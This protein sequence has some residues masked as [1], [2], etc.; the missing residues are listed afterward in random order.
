MAKLR[1]VVLAA[2]YWKALSDR[3]KTISDSISRFGKGR[4]VALA[5]ML[6]ELRS[7]SCVLVFDWHISDGGIFWGPG[8][9]AGRDDVDR[10]IASQILVML[11]LSSQVLANL[12]RQ[13]LAG[14]QPRP[15]KARNTSKA[16][17]MMLLRRRTRVL[18][19]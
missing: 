2:V 5:V 19:L 12:E 4:K 18:R 15:L 17:E 14:S 1:T 8:E 6:Q 13:P 3:F 7:S 16:Q 9:L 10:I 11:W